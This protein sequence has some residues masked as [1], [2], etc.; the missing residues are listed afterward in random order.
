MIEVILPV[1]ANIE[2]PKIPL[3]GQHHSISPY[4]RRPIAF[5]QTYAIKYLH[6]TETHQTEAVQNF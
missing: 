5:T 6:F 2:L 1:A 3:T 4:I